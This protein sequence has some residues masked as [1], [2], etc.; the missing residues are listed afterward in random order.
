M[1][2]GV[3]YTNYTPN[4]NMPYTR[5]R[6]GYVLICRRLKKIDNPVLFLKNIIGRNGFV[7]TDDL[8]EEAKKEGY[9]MKQ[10]QQARKEL[11]LKSKHLF[12]EEGP[13][14]N[15]IWYMP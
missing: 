3:I 4:A 14:D 11:G 1:F 10:M 8:R 6:E 12:D 15:W 7:N 13:L 9:T 2:R 5:V